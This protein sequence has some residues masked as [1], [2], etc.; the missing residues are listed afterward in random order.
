MYEL[1]GVELIAHALSIYGSA[2]LAAA[3]SDDRFSRVSKQ[4]V[5]GPSLTMFTDI[6]APNTPSKFLLAT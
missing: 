1:P 6:I 2:L 5:T 4:M 3:F